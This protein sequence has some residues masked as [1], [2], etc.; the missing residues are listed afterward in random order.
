MIPQDFSAMSLV[1]GSLCVLHIFSYL[2]QLVCSVVRF[3]CFAHVFP[4]LFWVWLSVPAQL[5]WLPGKTRLW[6]ESSEMQNSTPSFTGFYQNSLSLLSGWRCVLL[7]AASSNACWSVLKSA[8]S[9]FLSSQNLNS[10]RSAPH[11]ELASSLV[12][13][14]FQAFSI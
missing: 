1:L 11:D 8:T 7:P 6:N 14:S 10:V 9:H 12:S 4:R 2:G 5:S 3:L 13:T